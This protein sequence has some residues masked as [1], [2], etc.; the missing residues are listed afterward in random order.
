MKKRMKNKLNVTILLLCILFGTGSLFAQDENPVPAKLSQKKMYAD[1]DQLFSILQDCNPQ[2]T[3]R[4]AV[5]GIDQLQHIQSL[6]PAIDTIT[7]IDNFYEL[8]RTALNYTLDINTKE[9]HTFNPQYDNLK[10]IDTVYMDYQRD[11]SMPLPLP[12]VL[13]G[14]PICIKHD[15]FLPGI[16]QFI[17][18]AP[19]EK[20]TV[21]LHYSKIIS[22]NGIPFKSY[23][24]DNLIKSPAAGTRWDYDNKE[25]YSLSATIPLSGILIVEDKGKMMS[26]N[27][28]HK[29]RVITNQVDG[30]SVKPEIPWGNQ[31]KNK[32]LYLEKDQILYIYF[33]NMVDPQNE[34]PQKIKEIGKGKEIKKVIIDVRGNRGG[35]D[36]VWHNTLKAI[37]A[38]TLVYN[39]ILAFKNTPL[40]KKTHQHSN[41]FF[42]IKKLNVEVFD[43]LPGESFLT[44]NFKPQF[45]EPDD[46]SLNYKG[47]IFI[48]QDEKVYSA[49]HSLTSYA[50]HITQLVSVGEPCGFLAGFG[51]N[52]V[53][54][55]LKNS[56]FTFRME[57]T[58]DVSHVSEVIDVYQD[59][60]EV[61]IHIPIHKKLEYIQ[62]QGYDRQCETYL[63]KYDHLF[64]KVLE[65]K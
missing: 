20:D 13:M 12:K 60:P 10:K 35:S 54:F 17:N 27:L 9:S 38:H 24:Q 28:Y 7:N 59:F 49:A 39:P 64:Q 52:P 34:I 58:V 42:N 14:N 40:L 4:K 46:N 11:N 65:L 29:Y 19:G 5:T 23:V 53:L 18:S 26:L 63:Y 33:E 21:E 48:L 44:T 45:L 51:L 57:T 8:L 25:Y 56:K 22:Y 16:Y 32:V 55:Q 41:A 15:Y 61:R 3:I 62:D 47:K 50:R 1:F 30:Y 6:R 36:Y 31:Y 43:W 2:L 37:V